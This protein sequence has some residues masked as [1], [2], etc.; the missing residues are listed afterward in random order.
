MLEDSTSVLK[1]LKENTSS[2]LKLTCESHAMTEKE[3]FKHILTQNVF[4]F[5]LLENILKQ[6][7]KVNL[8]R[9]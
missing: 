3:V 5:L 6:E 9:Q 2:G 8:G 7:K 1:I 4:L